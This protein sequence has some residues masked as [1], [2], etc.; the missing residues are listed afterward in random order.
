MPNI[1]KKSLFNRLAIWAVLFA[2]LVSSAVALT[3]TKNSFPAF[4]GNVIT[5]DGSDIRISCQDSGDGRNHFCTTS[6]V[7]GCAAFEGRE[8]YGSSGCLITCQKEDKCSDNTP[9][10]QCSSNNPFYCDTGTLVKRSSFCG[11]VLPK[12][13]GGEDC[14]IPVACG[15]G[16]LSGQCSAAARPSF[17]SN[18]LLVNRASSCGCP[19]GQAASGDNCISSTGTQGTPPTGSTASAAGQQ[20]SNK[21]FI[22]D[23]DAKVDGKSSNNIRN[24]GRI[25]KDAK[26]NSEVE[27]AI[28]I[29]NNFTSSEG[30]DMQNI[31]ASASI[32]NILSEGGIEQESESFDLKADSDKTIRFKLR[33]PLNAEE[34]TYSIFIEADGE[35]ENGNN[36]KDEA[37]IELEVEKDAHDLKIVGFEISPKVIGCS[38]NANANVKIVNMGKEDEE[39]ALI[40]IKSDSLNL[41]LK[42]NIDIKA[43]SSGNTAARLLGFSVSSA[44][45]KGIYF[46]SANAYS[47]DGN[48]KDRRT[49]EINVENCNGPLES[50]NVIL[51][52]SPPSSQPKKQEKAA[53]LFRLQLGRFDLITAVLLLAFIILVLFALIVVFALAQGEKADEEYY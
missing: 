1:T 50:G 51:E 32:E 4:S 3:Y 31:V 9:F 40:E 2:L 7:N 13:R 11:C 38:R 25:S 15:D 12:V 6:G 39:N 20:V 27:L 24:D 43:D 45:E 16:T 5:C 10:G 23:I 42:S 34:G 37:D 21:L 30:I 19:S 41:G 18:G 29:K 26:P 46:I 33:I 49:A 22:I 53:S 36:H 8:N 44:A 14:I 35:D 28:G 52:I 47:E 17:C 48:L